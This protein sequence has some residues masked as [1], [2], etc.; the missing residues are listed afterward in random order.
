VAQEKG[1]SYIKFRKVQK[2]PLNEQSAIIFAREVTVV[3]ESIDLG[4]M[5]EWPGWK[6][7]QLQVNV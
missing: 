3:R 6:K 1:S 7:E 4:R 2:G 5:D